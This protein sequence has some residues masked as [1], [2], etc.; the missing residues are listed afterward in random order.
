MALSH[1]APC[2]YQAGKQ[3]LVSCHTCPPAFLGRPQKNNGGL[4][5]QGSKQQSQ[6]L[7]AAPLCAQAA[8]RAS[9][10]THCFLQLGNTP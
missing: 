1:P 8:P 9:Q 10:A 3:C 5:A 6:A 4:R 2:W 7:L